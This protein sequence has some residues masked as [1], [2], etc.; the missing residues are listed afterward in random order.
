MASGAHPEVLLAAN[1][2]TG[3]SE[4]VIYEVLFSQS[5]PQEFDA[6]SFTS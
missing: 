5:Y 2:A 4:T 1:A 3:T 6:L